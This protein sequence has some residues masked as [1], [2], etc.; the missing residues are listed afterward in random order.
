MQVC[1]SRPQEKIT[2]GWGFVWA[3]C[4][5]WQLAFNLLQ[6]LKYPFFQLY[7][8]LQSTMTWKVDSMVSL[9]VYCNQ[10][11]LYYSEPVTRCSIF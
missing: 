5:Q 11:L 6:G 1:Y 2:V 10:S 3:C 9:L 4:K 8:M 7:P